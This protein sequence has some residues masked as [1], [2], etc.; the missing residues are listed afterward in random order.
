VS[1]PRAQAAWVGEVGGG[2]RSTWGGKHERDVHD[3][4]ASELKIIFCFPAGGGGAA[5]GGAQRWS[6]LTCGGM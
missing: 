6:K 3:A 2:R 4:P 5:A 1:G